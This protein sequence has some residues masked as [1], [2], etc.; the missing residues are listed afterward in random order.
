MPLTLQ[1]VT[2][3]TRPGRK[4]PA[5]ARWAEGLARDHGAFDVEAVDLASFALPVFDEAAHPRLQQY[6]HAHTTAWSETVARADAFVF[7]HPEYNFF[8]PSSLVNAIT[9]LSKEW[10]RKPVGL[11]SYGGMSGGLRA[12][13]ALKPLLTALSMMPLA[14]NVALARFTEHLTGEGADAVFDPGDGAAQGM[15]TMLDALH[16]WAGALSALRAG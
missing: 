11:V 14:E 8:P 13:E 2:A 4:G 9:F 10:A 15:R 12:A 7:V 3:S 6:A 16:G 1:I 5:V